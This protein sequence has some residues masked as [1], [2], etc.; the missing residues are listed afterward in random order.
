[1]KYSFISLLSLDHAPCLIEADALF[2]GDLHKVVELVLYAGDAV[3]FADHYD[4]IV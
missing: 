4:M 3:A 2:S 1:M